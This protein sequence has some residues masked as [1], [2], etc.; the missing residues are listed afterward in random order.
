M[1]LTINIHMDGINILYPY[2]ILCNLGF[3]FCLY[4]PFFTTITRIINAFMWF[5]YFCINIMN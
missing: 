3:N 4:K 5:N 1:Y 2:I